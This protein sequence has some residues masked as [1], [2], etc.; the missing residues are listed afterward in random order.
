VVLQVGE[1]K[2]LTQLLRFA[3]ALRG[4]GADPP[5]RRSARG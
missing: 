5:V 3:P 4:D 1:V 2:L